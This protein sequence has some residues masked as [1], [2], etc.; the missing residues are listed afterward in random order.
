MLGSIRFRPIAIAPRPA[1]HG[2]DGRPNTAVMNSGRE[3]TYMNVFV[4]GTLTDHERADEVLSEYDFR[5]SALLEGLHRVDGTYPTLAPGGR[6][7][8]RLLATAEIDRLDRYEGVERGLYVRLAVPI[9][10]GSTAPNGFDTVAVYVGDPTAL[11]ADARWPGGG[12]FGER[13]ER[14]VREHAVTVR[15]H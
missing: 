12:S 10:D 9:A 1:R 8:G 7:D 14:Y 6:V 5:G 4:Y 13:V 2:I 3:V 15:L 11:G